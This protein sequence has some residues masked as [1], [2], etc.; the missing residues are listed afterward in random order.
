MAKYLLFLLVATCAYQTIEAC[1][2]DPV[3]CKWNPW[4]EGKCS[5]ECGDGQRTDTRTKKVHEK[6][7]GTCSGSS[8]RTVHCKEKECPVHCEWNDW[9]QGD[10]NKSCGGGVRT[11][12]RTENVEAKH[13]GE[14]CQGPSSMEVSCNTQECPVDCVWGDW[15]YGDCSADCGGGVQ[16]MMRVKSVLAQFGGVECEGEA[17]SEQECNT[18]P[19]P[20]D[21]TWNEWEHGE[22]S[23]TCAGGTRVDTRTIATEEMHGGFCDPEGDLRVETCNTQECPPIHCEWDEWIVGDCSAECGFGTRTNTRTK[24]VEEANGGT[25]SGQA[26]EIVECMEKECPV[27]CEWNDWVEGECS[28]ECGGGMK[29]NTRTEK[30]S[31]EHGGEECPGP[32]SEEVSCNEHECPVDCTWSEWTQG[33]CSVS[34]GE[35]SQV[36]T[37]EMFPEMFGGNP[38]EGDA[39]ETVTCTLDDCPV[40]PPEKSSFCATYVNIMASICENSW[41]TDENGRYS[42]QKSC[43]MCNFRK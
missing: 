24:L 42:C 28:K 22:C 8:T 25:C 16:P 33:P 23:V 35:G 19:C 4:N 7:G 36:N 32:D 39:A 9:V 5:A 38:C 6:D 29:T 10:C 20:V 18:H 3:H 1:S 26:S 31:A 43:G 40:C 30:V 15:Q 17:Y 37:R 12:T 2:K 14:A 13:G 11:D 21:C 27:H 41:F 34:C